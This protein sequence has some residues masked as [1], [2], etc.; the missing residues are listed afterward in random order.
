MRTRYAVALSL[1][2]SIATGGIAVRG[3][4]AQAKLKAYSIGEIVPI[5]GA[6]ISPSDLPPEI[7]TA[8]SWK[9]LNSPSWPGGD[10]G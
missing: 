5:A 4:H 10:W 3:L 9:I 7:W 1:L 6:A 8:D 2:A